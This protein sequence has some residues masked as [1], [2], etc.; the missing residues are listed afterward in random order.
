MRTREPRRPTPV[1]SATALAALLTVSAAV[2]GF[3]DFKEDFREGV[4]AYDEKKWDEVIVRMQSALNDRPH[5]DVVKVLIFGT[6]RLSYVPNTFLGIAY[7][8]L[9]RCDQAMPYFEHAEV[10]AVAPKRA[11]SYY[12]E[13]LDAR[14]SCL[15]KLMSTAVNEA[16]TAIGEADR[17]AARIDES[18]KTDEGRAELARNQA[19][20]QRINTGREAL[21]DAKARLE[22]GVSSSAYLTAQDATLYAQRALS[23]LGAAI[24]DLEAAVASGVGTADRA[25]RAAL[26]DATEARDALGRLKAEPGVSDLFQQVATLGQAETDA[27]DILTRA[28]NTLNTASSGNDAAGLESAQSLANQAREAFLT[29]ADQ[30][31]SELARR[32][33]AAQTAA[34][35]ASRARSGI[36][37]AERSLAELARYR[38]NAAITDWNSTLGPRQRTLEGQLQEAR[39]KL[40]QGENDGNARLISEA[41]DLAA[42]AD[43]GFLTLARDAERLIGASSGQGAGETPEPSSPPAPALLRTGAELYFKGEY[44]QVLDLLD[45]PTSFDDG[46]ARAQAHLFRA[47]AS[48]ALYQLSGKLDEPLR[49][50]VLDDIRRARGADDALAAS[51]RFF[52]PPFVDLVS[53]DD[54]S[55]D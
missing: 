30:T 35:A 29:A 11:Q 17:V 34:R 16:T 18:L 31:R 39:D 26:A 55:G 19:L 43:R 27:N 37:A 53:S 36:Q 5:A 15:D 13:M 33:S 41:T 8:N 3:A 54:S 44:Q 4:K 6:F 50:S 23:E 38:S 49:A 24:S 28:T 7:Y 22:A 1:R 52:P 48:F 20:E 14:N 45:D 9:D 47:A 21:R 42:S 51:S 10:Q 40:V 25:A 12:S 32:E 46:K 2:P